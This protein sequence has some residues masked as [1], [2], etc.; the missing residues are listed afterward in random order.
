MPCA[1]ILAACAASKP[2]AKAAEAPDRD[3]EELAAACTP[4]WNVPPPAVCTATED[5]NWQVESVPRL[6]QA[7]AMIGDR[8]W[9]AA[10]P[11]MLQAVVD[12]LDPVIREG[13][14]SECALQVA[15]W[16]R[17]RAHLAL[18]RLREAFLD[19]AS[20]VRAGPGHP[21]YDEVGQALEILAPSLPQ[22]VRISCAANYLGPDAKPPET[23]DAP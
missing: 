5:G 3:A 22:S 13:T 11:S 16:Y 20:V 21:F 7:V 17:G 8:G 10:G 23:Q 15:H 4:D 2:A 1:L 19:F 14:A 6:S 9:E 12:L 18:G